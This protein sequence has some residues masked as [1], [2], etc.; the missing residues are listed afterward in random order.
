[1]TFRSSKAWWPGLTWQERKRGGGWRRRGSGERAGEKGREIEGRSKQVM[2]VE[3]GRRERRDERRQ[4]RRGR[5]N[6]MWGDEVKRW[7]GKQKGEEKF[8]G[9]REAGGGDSLVWVVAFLSSAAAVKPIFLVGVEK[10]NVLCCRVLH[11]VFV[12]A[13]RMVYYYRYCSLLPW[14]PQ[15]LA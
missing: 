1:M 13:A 8:G 3:G 7:E 4:E 2:E 14:I 6:Q 5:G 15:V 12:E 11:C 10:Y 9:R